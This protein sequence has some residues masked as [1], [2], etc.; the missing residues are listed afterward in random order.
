L[1]ASDPKEKLARIITRKGAR[2]AKT[3]LHDMRHEAMKSQEQDWPSPAPLTLPDWETIENL[4]SPEVFE[5]GDSLYLASAPVRHVYLIRRGVVKLKC[6]GHNR[7]EMIVGIRSSGWLL[8]ADSAILSRP[9]VCTAVAISDGEVSVFSKAEFLEAIQTPGPLAHHLQVNLS[10]GAHAF[11]SAQVGLRS[12]SAQQRLEHFLN[13]IKA[14]ADAVGEPKSPL[15]QVEMAQLLSM[16]PEH[17]CRIMS[18][19]RQER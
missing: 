13:D 2:V 14:L 7:R 18:K 6:Y 16:T 9:Y 15:S 8:G 12:E 11:L 3:L 1:L 10:Q 5:A 17:L 19:K 4:P